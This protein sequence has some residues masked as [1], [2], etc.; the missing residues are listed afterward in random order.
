M[1]LPINKYL[2]QVTQAPPNKLLLFSIG[3][4]SPKFDLTKHSV[5]HVALDYFI[6]E[7]GGLAESGMYWDSSVELSPL[8]NYPNVYMAKSLEYMNN[9]GKAASAA[10]KK[11]G[12]CSMIVMHDDIDTDAGMVKFKLAS[13]QMGAHGGLSSIC[14]MCEPFERIRL[15]IGSPRS[16]DPGAVASYV[17]TKFTPQDRELL[18]NKTIPEAF[19]MFST[20]VETYEEALKKKERKRHH[21]LKKKQQQLEGQ[22]KSSNKQTLKENE[23]PTKVKK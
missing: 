16:R 3:N 7:L 15:G 20:I 18:H 22:L 11:L 8:K 4:P 6:R 19:E 21:E 23:S 9:S 17:M 14:K 10:Q 5:G 12:N 2:T 1:K 13:R